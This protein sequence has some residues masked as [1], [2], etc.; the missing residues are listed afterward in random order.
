MSALG[1]THRRVEPHAR[2]RRWETL[3]RESFAPDYKEQSYWLDR[4]PQMTELPDSPLP[5]VDCLVVGSGYTGLGA[6]LVTARS[7]R[8][9]M[10]VD[11][12]DPGSGVGPPFEPGA[13]GEPGAV[14]PS[15]LSGVAGV[16]GPPGA[17]GVPGIPG[18]PVFPVAPGAWGDP[19]F[20]GPPLPWKL[21]SPSGE[22]KEAV[23]GTSSLSVLG[24]AL[25]T[26]RA[27][28]PVRNRSTG[29]R[30]G[31]SPGLTPTGFA[32]AGRRHRGKTGPQGG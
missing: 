4:L 24:V 31:G 21:A 23:N 6:A 13:P 19:G 20:T 15:G 25:R 2:H 18:T 26:Q 27:P 12:G 11:S 1:L 5:V 16:L 10:V 14:S 7:G 22:L 28:G 29:H 3:K 9:T 8:S 17:P 30:P 32:R